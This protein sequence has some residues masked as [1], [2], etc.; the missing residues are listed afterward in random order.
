MPA[1]HLAGATIET[2]PAALQALTRS[3]LRHYPMLYLLCYHSPCCLAATPASIGQCECS[4]TNLL[5]SGANPWCPRK[6]QQHCRNYTK[7]DVDALSCNGDCAALQPEQVTEI[8]EPGGALMPRRMHATSCCEIPKMIDG[9]LAGLPTVCKTC[10]MPGAW[11][12]VVQKCR[13]HCTAAKE[14]HF[15]YK[16]TRFSTGVISEICLQ[17]SLYNGQ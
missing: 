17:P 1:A 5:L 10:H 8:E 16:G 3:D 11:Y 14:P 4:T 6:R 13:E 12:A 2:A 15:T 9:G 7:H